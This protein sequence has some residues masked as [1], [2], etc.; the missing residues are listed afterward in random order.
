MFF[1]C[2]FPLNAL[3]WLENPLWGAIRIDNSAGRF[4]FFLQ[5]CSDSFMMLPRYFNIKIQKKPRSKSKLQ[6]WNA[7]HHKLFSCS[8]FLFWWLPL[9]WRVLC[10]LFALSPRF[11]PPTWHRSIEILPGRCSLSAARKMLALDLYDLWGL[12]TCENRWEI[13]GGSSPSRFKW[14][15]W[16]I[17]VL[18]KIQFQVISWKRVEDGRSVLQ[19]TP[20]P[21]ELSHCGN[22]WG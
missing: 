6:C 11:P 13:S 18:S 1:L 2:L 8:M 5:M 22:L 9:F 10:F 15:S 20:W 19:N 17:I 14:C 21:I 7:G 12:G 4:V 16:R 3:T